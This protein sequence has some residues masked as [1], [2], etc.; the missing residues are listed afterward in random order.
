MG[1]LRL[2]RFSQEVPGLPTCPSCRPHLEVGAA[3]FANR[4]SW[5][6]FMANAS[7]F[8]PVESHGAHLLALTLN[9]VPRA[10]ASIGPSTNGG[11]A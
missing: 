1:E 7:A 3:V 9:A 11:A 2:R 10:S 4:T 5:R 8:T 6:P